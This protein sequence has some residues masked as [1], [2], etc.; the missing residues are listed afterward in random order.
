MKNISTF[1]SVLSLILISVLFYLHF[2]PKPTVK[3]TSAPSSKTPAADFRIAYFDIDS[4]QTHFDYFKKV[5]NEM[6]ARENAMTVELRTLE[7][8]YQKKIKEWQERGANMTQAEGEA[9]QREYAQMQQRYQKRQMDLEQE[10]QK[11]KVDLMT[12][13]RKKVEDYLKEYNKE[14]GYAFILSYE[15]GFM[16]YYKDTLYDVTTDLVTGLNEKYKTKLKD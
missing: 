16:L 7:N 13:L 9:A 1:L 8:S 4:L 2:S 5:S 3:T 14:K 15:P 12:D 6:K 11:Q 10:L